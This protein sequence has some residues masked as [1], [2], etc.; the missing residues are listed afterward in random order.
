MHGGDR[1]LIELCKAQEHQATPPLLYDA[2]HVGGWSARTFLEIR[3]G[4][5]RTPL[6][7][8]HDGAH[9]VIGRGHRQRRDEILVRLLIQG[10]EYMRAVE[11]DPRHRALA[12]VQ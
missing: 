11:T 8:K 7:G 9:C 12:A 2:F 4:A 6:T 10:I 3:S 1:W 5:E